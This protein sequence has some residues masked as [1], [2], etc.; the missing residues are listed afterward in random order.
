MAA[1]YPSSAKSF[2]SK[3]TGETIEVTHVTAIEEEVTAVETALVTGGLAHD[4]DP[5]ATANTRDL[6]SSA[7]RWRDAHVTGLNFP[8]TQVASTDANTLDDY[9]EGTWTPTLIGTGGQSG[10]AYTTQAGYYVKIGKLVHVYGRLTMSTLGTVTTQ[11]A[12]SGLPFTAENLST[13][14]VG[15]W[16]AMTTHLAYIGGLV[17]AN[18][19]RIELNQMAIAGA[20]GMTALAQGHMSDTSDLIF[21]AVYRAA[22]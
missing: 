9:E 4:L 11:A 5:D 22:A 15:Y 2:T 6:G 13:A 3:L 12:I 8:G 19:T 10:Q 16:S 17:V 18:T 21:S 14:H 20:T 1:S 7:K